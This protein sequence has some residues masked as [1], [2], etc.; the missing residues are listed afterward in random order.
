MTV[1][2][3]PHKNGSSNIAAFGYD[4]KAG[5]LHV[6]F[7]QEGPTYIYAGV[8][9]KLNDDMH[10]AESAGKFFHAH[11]KGKFTHRVAGQTSGKATK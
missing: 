5:E 6:K 1:T 8:S 3:K 2:L 7:R 10:A 11:I 4:P 9:A